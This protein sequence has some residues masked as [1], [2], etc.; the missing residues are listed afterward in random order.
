MDHSLGESSNYH[1]P[2]E[3]EFLEDYLN[4]ADL[5][6]VNE[7]NRLREKNRNSNY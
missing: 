4:A 2:T 5:L 7:E 1:R 3:D 6:T